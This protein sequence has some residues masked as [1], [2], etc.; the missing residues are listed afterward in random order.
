MKMYVSA[1]ALAAAVATPAFAADSVTRVSEK[2]ASAH[3]PMGQRMGSFIVT[4][5]ADVTESYNDN[6]Y[7]THTNTKSDFVTS[8][9]PEVTAESNW[10]R[11]AVNAKANVEFRKFA[12]HTSEDETNHFVGM[13]GRID[14]MRDTAIGGGVSWSRDHEDRGNPN[15]TAAAKEP[16]RYDTLTGKVGAYRSVGRLNGRIESK[17]ERLTFQDGRNNISNAVIDNGGRNRNEYT[18]SARVGYQ[19][20]DRFE[21]FAKGAVDTRAY[22]RDL[23]QNR[24][25]HGTSAVV[26]TAFDVTGKTKGEAYVGTLSRNFVDP[27]LKDRGWHS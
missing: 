2:M 10:N 27:A 9:K 22:D 4:P 16:T 13:D 11:H 3:A 18:Q 17:A 23:T 15:S 14:V 24:S 7:A 19:L 20:D 5:K 6:I 8:I 21:V 1:I 12:D 25:S 26:G